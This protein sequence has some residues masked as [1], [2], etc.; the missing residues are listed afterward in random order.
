M[1]LNMEAYINDIIVKTRDKGMLI[2]DL[3]ETF[4]NLSKVQL[5]LNPNKCAFGV[6]SGKLLGFLVSHR[7]IDANLD[8]IKS[9]KD[10]HF[11]RKVND[12]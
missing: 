1:G 9:I 8:K 7:G 12:V 10:I 4:D 3:R 2:E 11:P 6:P 5:K